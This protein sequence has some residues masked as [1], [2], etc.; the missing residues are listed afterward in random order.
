MVGMID[1]PLG[2]GKSSARDHVQPA[3][4]EWP[5]P[6]EEDTGTRGVLVVRPVQVADGAEER[7]LLR[8]SPSMTAIGD[9]DDAIGRSLRA[10]RAA[11]L[12]LPSPGRRPLAS[13]HPVACHLL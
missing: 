4:A 1:Q 13:D 8:P 6:P 2:W 12:G 10:R 9:R 3:N 7:E 11:R 5:G